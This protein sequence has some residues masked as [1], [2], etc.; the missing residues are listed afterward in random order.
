MGFQNNISIRGYNVPNQQRA[1]FRIG[2]IHT[3]AGLVLGGSTDSITTERTEV[4]RGP[5]SLLYG[6]NV[7]SGVTNIEP[8]RPQSEFYGTASVMAG[9]DNQI[10]ATLDVTGPLIEDKLSYRFMAAHHE[11]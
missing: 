3:N 4:V 2:F 8:K 7:L 6:I 5:Q 10:R 1:G 9:S 11:F